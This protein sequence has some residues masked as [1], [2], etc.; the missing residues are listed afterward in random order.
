VLKLLHLFLFLLIHT[1]FGVIGAGHRQETNQLIQWQSVLF[2]ARLLSKPHS[3]T[4]Q[5]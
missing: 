2:N 1:L 3:T 5:T 4:I